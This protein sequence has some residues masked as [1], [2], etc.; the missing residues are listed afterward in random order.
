MKEKNIGFKITMARKLLDISQ[1]DLAKK[2]SLSRQ[3]LSYW[4]N[5]TAIPRIKQLEKLAQVLKK[6]ISYFLDDDTAFTKK[7]SEKNNLLYPSANFD[8]ND[9]AVH[10]K[11]LGADKVP[12]VA[13]IAHAGVVIFTDPS[14]LTDKNTLQFTIK[15]AEDTPYFRNGDKLIFDTQAKPR[16]GSLVLL[17]EDKIYKITSYKKN[18]TGKIIATAIFK[19][20]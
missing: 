2:L 13:A 9:I 1:T 3:T 15:T 16:E 8:I 5:G 10:N 19:S 4:E 17:L 18:I 7:I 20:I 6:D 14:I 11:F 12:P